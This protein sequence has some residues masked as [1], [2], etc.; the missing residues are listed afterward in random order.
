MNA[1]VDVLILNTAVL[2]LRSA[3]FTF[4]DRLVGPGGLAKCPQ[5]VMPAFSQDQFRN[6][7]DAGCATA[8]GPGNSAPLMA[9][10]G[11][12]VAIGANL[13]RGAFDGL[14]I[15][16]RSVVDL[17][18]ANGVD[19]SYVFV[20][21]S[22]PTGTTF[23]HDTAGQERGGIAYFAGAND[24]FS[25]ERFRPV[26]ERLAPAIVYYMYSGLS[27]RGDAH[28]GRD[29]AAFMAWCRGRGCLTIADA[30]TLC[31][32]P[33]DLISAGSG[34]EQYAL[35]SPL[36]PE[37]DIFF[38]S[39]DEARLIHNTLGTP[40]AW[41]GRD[42]DA[43]IGACLDLLLTRPPVSDA[44]MRL[45]GITVGD[46]AWERHTLPTGAYSAPAKIASRFMGTDVI[47]LVGAGDSFRAGLLSYVVRHADAFRRRTM[48]VREAIQVGNLFASRFVRAPLHDR[49]AGV[50]RFNDML[51]VVRR[52]EKDRRY[53]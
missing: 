43:E 27:E 23:I 48:D 1:S 33:R 36:L 5:S 9:R 53:D 34:L 39:F 49:Y 35:L 14:D 40:R 19:M 29:L 6:W 24:D 12:R 28:E 2:D 20:H 32:N 44:L 46:G 16:G 15:Q 45:F 50:R 10:A 8:G 18:T 30:H 51:D 38:T 22:L 13:G 41:D 37:L 25:F 47:D 17:M 21:P 11:L 26:V 31:A 4:A 7:I 42:E 52:A 3:D